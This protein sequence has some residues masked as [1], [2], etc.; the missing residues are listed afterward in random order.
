MEAKP[1]TEL[2][3]GGVER[4]KSV[5]NRQLIDFSRLTKREKLTNYA[6]HTR[7][8]HAGFHRFLFARLESGHLQFARSSFLRRSRIGHGVLKI[9]RPNIAR[10]VWGAA[11]PE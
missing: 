5:E 2:E 9:T 4:I 10:S 11:R 1:A 3:A 7:I 6:F 8:T